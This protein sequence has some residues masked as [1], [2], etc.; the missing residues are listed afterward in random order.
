MT[1]GAMVMDRFEHFTPHV[2]FAVIRSLAIVIVCVLV[3]VCFGWNLANA[4]AKDDTYYAK[5]LKDQE[6][7]DHLKFADANI[8][9]LKLRLDAMQADS[10]AR[11]LQND[12]WKEATLTLVSSMQIRMGWDEGIAFGA[13]IV[14][15]VLHTIGLL[16]KFKDPSGKSA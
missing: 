12:Q 8:T 3:T 4:T 2:K 15:G 9:D 10:A 16:K 1:T 5:T 7:D 13:F 14:I 11:R 6:Q